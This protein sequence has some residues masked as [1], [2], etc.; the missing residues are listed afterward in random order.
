MRSTDAR[1]RIAT[2]VGTFLVAAA[3]VICSV[4]S[5]PVTCSVAAVSTSCYSLSNRKGPFEIQVLWLHTYHRAQVELAG[6]P[7]YH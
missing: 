1:P 6:A 2:K 4:A 5:A 3:A 7:E